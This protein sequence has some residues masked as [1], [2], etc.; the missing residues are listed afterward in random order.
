MPKL[1]LAPQPR[2]QRAQRLAA[3]SAAAG[4]PA[5]AA[6][7]CDAMPAPR[8]LGAQRRHRSHQRE[9]ATPPESP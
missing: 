3:A 1:A 7:G 5:D 8:H 2:R 9:G 4:G 6:K